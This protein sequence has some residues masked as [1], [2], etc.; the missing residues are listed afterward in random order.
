LLESS[1]C[2]WIS[3]LGVNFTNVLQAAFTSSDLKSAKRQSSHQCL[4]ALLG[5]ART[6]AAHKML[7]KLTEGG[8]CEKF[9]DYHMQTLKGQLP[10]HK[11]TLC[12][13]G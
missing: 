6:K 9:E 8:E 4:F 1:T 2:S 12:T 13:I 10:E 3:R 5:S 7:E 11:R